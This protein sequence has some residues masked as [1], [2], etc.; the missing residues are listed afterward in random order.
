MG[1]PQNSLQ[2][3]ILSKGM[4]WGTLINIQWGATK[5]HRSEYRLVSLTPK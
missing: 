4:I 2:W 5:Q 3:K 1:V